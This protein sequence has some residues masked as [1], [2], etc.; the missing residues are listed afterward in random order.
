MGVLL[1]RLEAGPD[2]G[3][4]WDFQRGGS[5]HVLARRQAF[6][7]RDAD[8][9]FLPIAQEFTLFQKRTAD[10]PLEVGLAIGED[11][12]GCQFAPRDE[13][14]DLHSLALLDLEERIFKLRHDL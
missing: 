2:L 3:S 14:E 6:F 5:F 12:H 9:P 4:L 10:F 13:A 8:V 11:V 1:D 7:G